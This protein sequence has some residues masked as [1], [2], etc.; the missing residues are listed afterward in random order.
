MYVPRRRYRQ[1]G[2][3]PGLAPGRRL[4]LLLSRICHV[5]L[6]I[7]LPPIRKRERQ[8]RGRPA[9]HV[10]GSIGARV[11]I[12]RTR[13]RKAMRLLLVEDDFKIARFVTSGLKQAGF[14]V[15]HAVPAVD[16]DACPGI[17]HLVGDRLFGFLF[18]DPLGHDGASGRGA[19]GECRQVQRAADQRWG[20]GS[21]GRHCRP[22]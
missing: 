4:Q 18:P 1:A 16:P 20:R 12:G 8:P 7:R 13:R 17:Q 11:L 19:A 9:E 22:T 6:R 14:A 5:F 3:G 15:D 10:S 2:R 21:A